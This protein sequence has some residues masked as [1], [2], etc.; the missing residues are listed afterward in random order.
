MT[1]EPDY[2]STP[3]GLTDADVRHAVL[4]SIRLLLVLSVVAAAL[5]WW[6]LNWQSAV[7]VIVGSAI[8]LTSLWEWLRLMT[9]MNQRMDSG[10]SPR[11]MGMILFGFFARL[12]LTVVVLYVSLKFL[13]GTVLALATGLGLGLVSLSIEAFRLLKRTTA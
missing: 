10:Q 9:A 4:A 1:D 13:H 12:A 6:R 3:L 2:S 11:P 5:F 7:L 8:S